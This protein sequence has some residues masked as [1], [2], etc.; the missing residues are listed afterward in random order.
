M[1]EEMIKKLEAINATAPAELDEI[2]SAMLAE[3][4]AM[5]DDSIV[6]LDEFMESL[7]GYGGKIL[8]RIPKSLHKRLANEAHIEG[9]SLNQ[10]ALYKLSR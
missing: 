2:D 7:E 6:P 8:L 10:Y 5:G 4:E 1:T 3:A 9:V